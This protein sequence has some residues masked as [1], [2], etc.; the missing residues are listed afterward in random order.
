MMASI[1][2]P[3]PWRQGV[4][5]PAV[6]KNKYDLVCSK[7]N[8]VNINLK[9]ITMKKQLLPLFLL[10]LLTSMSFAG[11]Y[12]LKVTVPDTVTVCY[13]SGDFNGWSSPGTLMNQVSS[14]PKVFT[15]DVVMTDTVGKA[16]KF[17]AGPDWKYQQNQSAN[18]M[19]GTLTAAG[20]TVDG[21]QAIYNAGMAKDITF[22]VLVP[23]SIFVV[24]LTGSYNG[25]SGT[26]DKMTR[27]DSSVNG[28]E[29]KITVH[30]KD[31]STLEYKFSAGPGWDYQQSAGNYKYMTDGSTVVCDQFT[32]IFNP[33][34]VGNI[35]VN[36]TVPAGTPDVWLIGSFEGWTADSAHALHAT[37]NL[38]GTWTAVIPQVQNVQFKCYNSPG[39]T[40][41]EAAD[42]AGS[43]LANNRSASFIADPV[44]NITVL[45]WKQVFVGIKQV[46]PTSY[47]IYSNNGSVVVEGVN[48]RVTVYDI[49][50]RVMESRNVKGSFVS[51]SLKTGIY[52]VTV[53][54]YNQKIFVR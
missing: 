36:I 19:M 50:G 42:A 25:W 45:F 1:L 22:D 21:F 2:F 7:T 54:G 35:T 53:D 18:Y 46:L 26:M 51:G 5:L 14:G 48:S 41:E 40:Y 6:G 10:L 23:D 15:L 47:R 20:V 43:N 31:T 8:V 29:F 32:A 30:I 11:N 16:Y 52:I 12:T 9:S 37:K 24:Y 3:W 49:M 38:D 39:W 33:A 27:A 34:L 44:V 17:C 28:E 13:A 4:L